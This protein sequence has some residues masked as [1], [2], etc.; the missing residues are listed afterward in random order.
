MQTERDFQHHPTQTL[1]PRGKWGPERWLDL[2]K[3]THF[4]RCTFYL[5]WFFFYHITPFPWNL[6]E[7]PWEGSQLEAKVTTQS[8]TLPIIPSVRIPTCHCPQTIQR[9]TPFPSPESM[10]IIQVVYPSTSCQLWRTQS[11]IFSPFRYVE[12]CKQSPSQAS[13]EAFSV[14]PGIQGRCEGTQIRLD[15]NKNGS[16]SIELAVSSLKILKFHSGSTGKW[17]LTCGSGFPGWQGRKDGNCTT[18]LLGTSLGNFLDLFL[19]L[20][21]YRK[22]FSLKF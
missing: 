21:C 13:T 2:P 11:N 6:S 9:D 16:H 1:Y 15:M 5:T 22:M 18:C 17:A 10:C 8:A 14:S 12:L 4:H 20:L 19:D 7:I 3:V